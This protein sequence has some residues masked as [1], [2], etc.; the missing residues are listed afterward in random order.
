MRM[1]AFEKLGPNGNFHTLASAPAWLKA[2]L[3]LA[4]QKIPTVQTLVLFGDDLP[5]Y[6][7]IDGRAHAKPIVEARDAELTRLCNTVFGAPPTE[8]GI[9]SGLANT[10]HGE[11]ETNAIQQDNF[12][13]DNVLG[14][15]SNHTSILQ[16]P[17]HA[18]IILPGQS[19]QPLRDLFLTTGIDL[20]DTASPVREVN[21]H[22]PV[23]WH[24]LGHLHQQDKAHAAL[25]IRLNERNADTLAH[26]GSLLAG[27]PVAAQYNLDWRVLST[28]LSDTSVNHLIYWN[29]LSVLRPEPLGHAETA[30][31][32]EVKARATGLQIQLPKNPQSI[33]RQL[34]NHGG[35]SPVSAEFKYSSKGDAER[36]ILTLAGRHKREPYKY[37]HSHELAEMVLGAAYRIAPQRFAACKLA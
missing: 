34:S 1:R 7:Q 10:Y 23:L 21:Y 12:V 4:A 35:W 32:L 31:Y 30:A 19:R 8:L 24:E 14:S 13:R 26:K 17:T 2:D 20:R 27:D 11:I 16:R 36:K 5:D 22:R 25:S 33:M 15:V 37:P 9:Q 3:A 29:S 6:N 28:F 18:I